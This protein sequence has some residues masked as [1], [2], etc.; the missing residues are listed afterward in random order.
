MHSA[1]KFMCNHGSSYAFFCYKNIALGLHVSGF[2]VHPLHLLKWLRFEYSDVCTC[3]YFYFE[4]MSIIRSYCFCPTY[5][6]MWLCLWPNFD[7]VVSF[8]LARYGTSEVSYF[9]AIQ[10][11]CLQTWTIISPSTW[12][13][14]IRRHIPSAK[15]AFTIIR[16]FGF[17]I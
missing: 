13:A 15:P 12:F 6:L 8:R 7:T 4:W 16:Y 3:I 9:L 2:Q 11:C 10:T 5:W 14:I 17:S 1:A